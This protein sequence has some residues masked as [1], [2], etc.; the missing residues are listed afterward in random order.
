MRVR[1]R[2]RERVKQKCKKTKHIYNMVNIHML[3]YY[4]LLCV[5]LSGFFFKCGSR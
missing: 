4:K 3:C 2:E 5:T 1:E